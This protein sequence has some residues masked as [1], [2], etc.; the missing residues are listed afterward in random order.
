MPSINKVMGGATDMK[1]LPT[2]A[3]PQSSDTEWMLKQNR[4]G[5]DAC[6]QHFKEST[7]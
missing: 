5:D 4:F 2:A 1:N 3:P 6:L 7:D